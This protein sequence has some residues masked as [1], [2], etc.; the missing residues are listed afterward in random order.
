MLQGVWLKKTA[1]ASGRRVLEFHDVTSLYQNDPAALSSPV[2]RRPTRA[3][4][5]KE[6]IPSMSWLEM[7]SP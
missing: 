5:S 2:N 6:A 3:G 7:T 1:F 4:A